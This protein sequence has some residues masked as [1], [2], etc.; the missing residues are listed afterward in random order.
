MTQH[1]SFKLP[2]SGEI[3]KEIQPDGGIL[4]E[5][6]TR[7][8]FKGKQIKDAKK[9]EIFLEIGRVVT[10]R[11]LIP[12]GMLPEPLCPKAFL[13]KSTH[14]GEVGDGSSILGKSWLELGGLIRTASIIMNTNRPTVMSLYSLLSDITS[15]RVVS[16]SIAIWAEL[17]DELCGQLQTQ[18]A[19]VNTPQFLAMSCLRLAVIDIAL[20]VSA[21]LWLAK[22]PPPEEETPLWAMEKGESI[23]LKHLLDGCSNKR[24]TRETLA[25]EIGVSDTTVDNWL[26]TATRPNVENVDMIAEILAPRM[27]NSEV[28]ALKADLHC[29]YFLCSIGNRVADIV[30]RDNV[31]E[32]ANA[33]VRLVRHS[34][35][36]LDAL[37]GWLPYEGD[38][39]MQ[40]LLLIQ[41]APSIYSTP[42]LSELEACE[43]NPVWK[44]DLAVAHM[45]WHIRLRSIARVASGLDGVVDRSPDE[46]GI[47]KE[48]LDAAKD[49]ILRLARSHS[50]DEIESEDRMLAK[51]ADDPKYRAGQQMLLAEQA[52]SENDLAT[53]AKRFI[54]ASELQP[55]S[56]WYHFHAGI[57][58]GAIGQVEE[59]VAECKIA[60]GLDETWE[61]PK[62]ETGVI[63][64]NSDNSQKARD[65][66]E[67]IACGNDDPSVRLAT[68]LGIARMK[69]GEYLGGL[70]MLEHAISKESDNGLA[71]MA[72]ANCAFMLD[73]GVKG[74]RLAKRA[75]HVGYPLPYEMWDSGMYKAYKAGDL[76][77]LDFNYRPPTPSKPQ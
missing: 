3:I 60:A 36:I 48:V 45:P 38:A 64:L 6:T 57:L 7:R 17:W 40:A 11:G 25:Q 1:K 39:M 67:T 72:A 20:R 2:L 55:H 56:A 66:L 37:T 13:P 23:Y 53:A 71:L 49:E 47:P 12:H 65:H 62:V 8:Y 35:R 29:H 30:G 10:D 21:A 22:L 16:T 33:L 59:G 18:S 68:A 54:R 26:D 77:W 32:L 31:I 9:L 27:I 51:L 41:G 44:A 4:S 14:D 50:D 58:L 76:P 46:L 63:W 28:S 61:T 5:K 52:L 74:R 42:L 24:P 34:M 75:K 15:D 70:K 19:P 73:D 69:C 43:E